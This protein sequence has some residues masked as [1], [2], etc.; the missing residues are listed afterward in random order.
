MFAL[1]MRV[2]SE[3]TCLVSQ[4]HTLNSYVVVC[5]S[6]LLEAIRFEREANE[7]GTLG[8]KMLIEAIV[9]KQTK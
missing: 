1:D 3:C 9:V 4:L 8:L 6:C 5:F 7:V 2:L